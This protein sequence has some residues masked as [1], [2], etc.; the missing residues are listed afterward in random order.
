MD[1]SAVGCQPRNEGEEEEPS[2]RI[3]YNLRSNKI[4]SHPDGL[5]DDANGR[6]NDRGTGT[7]S[8]P[9]EASSNRVVD[10]SRR[11]VEGDTEGRIRVGITDRSSGQSSGSIK[12]TQTQPLSS[13][14]SNR[15]TTLSTPGQERAGKESV[16]M[17]GNA[18]NTVSYDSNFPHESLA[19]LIGANVGVAS[20]KSMSAHDINLDVVPSCSGLMDTIMGSPS[21]SS[22]LQGHHGD[23]TSF[24]RR[25][26]PGIGVPKEKFQERETSRQVSI[27][28]SQVKSFDTF[29]FG[30]GRGTFTIISWIGI[31]VKIRSKFF[32]ESEG[33]EVKKEVYWRQRCQR[34]LSIRRRDQLW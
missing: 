16:R 23:R 32:Q 21:S 12:V 14:P 11:E 26:L 17:R 20:R 7:E 10:A 31:Q 2:S 1:H 24:D 33:K 29:R 18:S 28:P 8:R 30:V 6:I 27:N 15:K 34:V 25:S 3:R 5:P 9:S 22:I 4:D 13:S 19:P